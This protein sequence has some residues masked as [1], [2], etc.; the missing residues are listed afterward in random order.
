[1]S[2]ERTS[3][4]LEVLEALRPTR[5][6]LRLLGRLYELLKLRL[7]RCLEERGFSV[8]VEAEGSYAKGTLL[9]DKWE[10]DVFVLFN[11]VSGEWV[12][13]GSLRELIECIKPLPYVTK[14]AEHPYL[15][16]TLM[17]VEVEVI[18]AVKLE[19]PGGGRLGVER[20]PFHTRY[21]KGK[22]EERPC[23]ADD[24]RLLKSFMEGI[25]VYGAE[26]GVGGFSG[27]LAELLVINYGGFLEVLRA[28]SRWRPQ[29]Y[30]DPEGLGDE[31]SLR[32][33]YRDSPLIV[34]DPVDP[35]RNAAASVTKEKLATFILASTLYL[36]K[37]HK[38]YF[39]LY[40][41][42]STLNPLGPAVMVR[43]LGEY[44]DMPRESVMGKLRRATSTLGSILREHG[45]RVTWS[46][47][48]SD[49][50]E[51]AA[52]IV[53]LESLELPEVE[54]RR[55]PTPWDSIEGAISF[56]FKRLEEGGLAW[57]GE[58]GFLE[59]VRSRRYRRPSE[60]L[61]SYVDVIKGVM[62]ARECYV[63]ECSEGSRCLEASGLRRGDFTG[64]L[65]AAW[66][67]LAYTLLKH[68]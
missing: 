3:V 2:C 23:L 61:S 62:S 5:L 39:H 59:G 63:V 37:P 1:M 4:E 57:V 11:G 25:G 55:G 12:K 24:I 44:M 43:C 56:L 52:I 18:P 67:K 48:A 9:S 7:A 31:R 42:S 36:R 65:Q 54:Y 10:V 15:T 26:S 17:G 30:I 21:V 8:E 16:V 68:G 35:E 45:F 51:K 6:Q 58:E 66:M 38:G 64:G 47:Y 19:K 27:Y 46:S 20:T 41:T 49:F 28:S 32:A 53:G 50:V 22:L 14:Y 40:S 13:E 33:K 29:V 60:V 34:V